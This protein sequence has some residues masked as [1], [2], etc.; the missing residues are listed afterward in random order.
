MRKKLFS[1]LALLLVAATG[2][3]AQTYTVTVKQGTKDT[4]KW[5]TDP[6][7][8]NTTGEAQNT[9]V[10]VTYTGSKLVMSV[11]AKKKVADPALPEGA[12]A[13]KFTINAEDKQVYFS[14]GNLQAKCE[15][16]DD[17]KNTPEEWTWK[18]AE[19]QWDFIGDA[20]TTSTGNGNIAID[21]YC[22]VSEPGTVDLFRWSAESYKLGI[23]N[24]LRNDYTGAF[25]DWGGDENVQKGI[26]T[27]WRTMTGGNDGEWY[28]LLNTRSVT[29][30]YC[31]ATVNGKTGLV[32]FPDNYSH[33]D[34]VTAV[35]SANTKNVAFDSNTWDGTN[36]TQMETAGAVFLPAAGNNYEN[37]QLE[38][39][40]WNVGT[41]GYYWSS[42]WSSTGYTPGHSAY[43][44][45]FNGDSMNPAC[46]TDRARGCS[47][48]LVQELAQDADKVTMTPGAT[49]NT[50]S[51][52][53]PAY[54]VELEVEYFD[55]TAPTATEGD[56]YPGSS[57][58]L[59]T[60]GSSIN[61]TLMYKVTAENTKPISTEGFK[62]TVTAEDCPTA[63]TY[64][65]WYYID[66][67]S[68]VSPIVDTAV[69][70][71]VID[72][73][74][75]IVADMIYDLPAAADVTADDY[76]DI[77]AAREAYDALTKEQKN[78]VGAE[79]L[80]KLKAAEEAMGQI[81]TVNVKQGTEDATNWTASPNPTKEGQTVTVTYTGSKLVKSLKAKKKLPEGALAGKFT[82]NENGDKVSFSKGNLQAYCTE[83][84]GNWRTP[85]TW[86]W[87]FADNQWDF[88]GDASTTPSGNGNTVLN[89]YCSVSKPGTVDLFRWSTESY[90]LGIHDSQRDIYTGAF[91]DWGSDEDV[92]DGIGKGWRTL[93]SSEWTYLFNTRACSTVNS[94]ENARFCKAY[95]F[96]TIHGII[97]FPD[98]Y[99]HPDGVDEPTGINKTDNTS[100]DANQYNATDWGKMEAAGAVFLPAAGY[101]YDMSVQKVGTPLPK[102]T[103][104]KWGHSAY[105][106]YFQTGSLNTATGTYGSL[107][108]RACSVRLVHE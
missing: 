33:P 1:I 51:L 97:L 91:V 60:G 105:P 80:E 37:S 55:L 20:S 19:H 24:T 7:E 11:K 95:L 23:H 13:G 6:K 9:E 18:F 78:A 59:V 61:G 99:T 73:P 41:H 25:V 34:G 108:A 5:T 83:V 76:A 44:L 10:T 69:E 89:G 53:M 81:Y 102:S 45:Y 30:R 12:L 4:D 15:S 2:A 86:T 88:I 64:Y 85:E 79:V 28:Y 96:G 67:T 56:I 43:A 104:S 92:Q 57:T 84:D 82:I 52:T 100:W 87:K 93:T 3:M 106:M 46:G 50:W 42:T 40:I 31:K 39:G 62:A 48:R 65:V 72:T 49:A 71:T 36:W 101:I 58:A 94:T 66:G 54:N 47:V 29:Y 32:I 75:N 107:R 17:N 98:S 8:A 35:A 63:G 14:K 103:Y 21:G 26:G 27:G 90:K 77:I 68:V 74:E 16:A 38:L 70:V 22:S